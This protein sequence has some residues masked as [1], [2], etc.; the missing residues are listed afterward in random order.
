MAITRKSFEGLRPYWTKIED[1]P[2]WLQVLLTRVIDARRLVEARLMDRSNYSSTLHIRGRKVEEL[3]FTGSSLYDK[4]RDDELR[5]NLRRALRVLLVAE[6]HRSAPSPGVSW[7]QNKTTWTGGKTDYMIGAPFRQPE[8]DPVDPKSGK[9][10]M[11]LL[12]VLDEC[13]QWGYW[14]V[15]PLEKHTSNKFMFT[16]YDVGEGGYDTINVPFDILIACADFS[17]EY[18]R[19]T[20][21]EGNPIVDWIKADWQ[22]V[23]SRVF[24]MEAEALEKWKAKELKEFYRLTRMYGPKVAS[25]EITAE[26]IMKDAGMDKYFYNQFLTESQ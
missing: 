7:E 26:D 22:K 18:L 11:E 10:P 8:L 13:I 4:V 15:Q 17:E 25:G 16:F 20:N 5:E 12:Y 23:R 9:G 14:K 3:L 24:A 1:H 6:G 2:Q 19:D 21:R